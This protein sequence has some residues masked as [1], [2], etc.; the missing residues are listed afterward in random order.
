MSS[1]APDNSIGD[2]EGAFS[3]F[4]SVFDPCSFPISARLTRGDGDGDDFWFPFFSVF[5][6]NVLL[7]ATGVVRPTDGNR[8]PADPGLILPASLSG[9]RTGVRVDVIETPDETRVRTADPPP[10]AL[11]VPFLAVVPTV[12]V[13]MVESVD[14]PD[15]LRDRAP[16]EPAE[17]GVP[18]SDC[19]VRKVDVSEVA[20]ERV[21]FGRCAQDGI[22][23]VDRPFVP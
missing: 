21:E 20:E 19:A 8:F 2:T 9:R 15:A 18:S 7:C 3:L 13:L 12:R 16:L 6:P 4:S 5:L 14:P 1:F 10:G 23:S 11:D 17:V 22:R